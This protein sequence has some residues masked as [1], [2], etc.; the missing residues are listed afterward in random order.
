MPALKQKIFEAT[1][2]LR[3]FL[4]LEMNPA[5]AERMQVS[6]S[7][8]GT[9]DDCTGFRNTVWTFGSVRSETTWLF[10]RMEDLEDRPVRHEPHIGEPFGWPYYKWFREK[11]SEPEQ[12]I[13]IRYK[14][15][16][17]NEFCSFIC[18]QGRL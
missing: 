8:S 15:T 1:W 18:S 11:H 12:L 10:R 16:L 4:S 7:S 14:N 2:G 9:E 17:L 5:H 13:A 3:A 6:E